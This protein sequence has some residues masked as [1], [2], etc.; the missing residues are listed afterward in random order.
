MCS[1]DVG[2]SMAWLLLALSRAIGEAVNGHLVWMSR[3]SVTITHFDCAN[4]MDNMC[5][6]QPGMKQQR[7]AILQTR[8]ETK[9]M[10]WK[11]GLSART[12]LF[13]TR[14]MLGCLGAKRMCNSNAK[15]WTSGMRL[16]SRNKLHHVP[17]TECRAMRSA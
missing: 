5:R 11:P 9:G 15:T 2:A 4:G 14:K 17:G 16:A 1:Y 12:T 7:F 3:C 10:P 13:L 8:L 6:S